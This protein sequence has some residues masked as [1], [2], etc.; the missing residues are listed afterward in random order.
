MERTRLWRTGCEESKPPALLKTNAG[1]SLNTTLSS[2]WEILLGWSA[3]KKIKETGNEEDSRCGGK[4]VRRKCESKT[5]DRA[6]SGRPIEL[7]LRAGL[8][9]RS[10]AASV[11]PCIIICTATP[12]SGLKS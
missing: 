8:S 2:I 5:D 3:G 10:S 11:S 6:G 12:A 4:E 9:G 1:S 7:V